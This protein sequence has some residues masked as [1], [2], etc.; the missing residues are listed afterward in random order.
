MYG[1]GSILGRGVKDIVDKRCVVMGS[2]VPQGGR[3]ELPSNWDVRWVRGPYSA[4]ALGVSGELGVGDPAILL[5]ELTHVNGV[6]GDE[7]SIIPHFKSYKNFD[8]QRLSSQSDYKVINPMGP[9]EAVIAGIRNSK[10]VLS[11]SLHGAIFSDTMGIPWAPLVLSYKF[12]K[13]KWLD[14]LATIGRSF[15]PFVVD[16]P[17][18]NQVKASKILP[19]LLARWVEFSYKTFDARLRPIHAARDEDVLAVRQQID[20]FVKDLAKFSA[21]PS[22]LIQRQ[23]NEMMKIIG[24]FNGNMSEERS[25]KLDK[26]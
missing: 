19:N 17:L 22:E 8:W 6:H 26:F 4:E 15:E 3:I 24:A 18:V 9:L 12:N 11:E 13:L 23:K 2:G 16:R 1:V 5:P 21:S 20:D 7:I 10:L 25:S 14:W